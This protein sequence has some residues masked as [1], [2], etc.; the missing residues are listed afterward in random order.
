MLGAVGVVV[1]GT[2]VRVGNV[3]LVTKEANA[4]K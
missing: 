1:G 3:E 4:T 2:V